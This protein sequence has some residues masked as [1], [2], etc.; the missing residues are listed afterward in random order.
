MDR[1]ASVRDMRYVGQV[2]ADQIHAETGGRTVGHLLNHFKGV[3]VADVRA[4]IERLAANARAG[5]QTGDYTV[6]AFNRRVCASISSALCW[7]RE[8]EGE[9]CGFA[10]GLDDLRSICS[11]YGGD[12]SGHRHACAGPKTRLF[13]NR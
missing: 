11:G 8:C 6:P 12:G 4:R 5:E 10:C 2:M 9:S 7:A 3:A 1:G 13:R